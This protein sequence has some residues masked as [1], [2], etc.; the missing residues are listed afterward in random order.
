MKG[1]AAGILLIILIYVIAA[2]VSSLQVDLLDVETAVEDYNKVVTAYNK[3][4]QNYN[5]I[6]DKILSEND[7]L[8]SAIVNAQK[9]SESGEIPFDFKTSTLLIEKLAVATQALT[10]KHEKIPM[11]DL[12]M[13]PSDLQSKEYTTYCEELTRQLEEIVAQQI[14]DIPEI[15]DYSNIINE[16]ETAGK[17]YLSSVQSMKQV[18]VPEENFVVERL[19][20]I[21]NIVGLASV[22]K[23]N[24]PNKLLG[25]EGG[26]VCCLYFSDSRIDKTKLNIP[27][28][29]N[30][31]IAIGTVGGGSIEVFPSTEDAITRNKYL[32]S[33]DETIIN[34]GAHTVVGTL[35]IRV[36]SKLT[37]EQQEEMTNFIISALTSIE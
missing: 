35:V 37:E 3:K 32:S 36:S 10:D 27:A 30:N 23:E 16:L 8:R 6:V 28:G 26:Y 18:T 34:P 29:K 22:T 2:C 11:C 12:V 13:M 21:D 5:E 24:D 9:I 31:V 14:P 25:T 1:I 20:R 17:A 7:K 19:K 33:F 15:P 4:A